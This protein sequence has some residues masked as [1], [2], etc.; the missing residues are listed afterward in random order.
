MGHMSG[1]WVSRRRAGFVLV[2]VVTVFAMAATAASAANPESAGPASAVAVFEGRPVDLT[3]GWQ[4]AQA[5][6]V[7][8]EMLDA[9]EC[10]SSEAQLEVRI[11]ELGGTLPRQQATAVTTRAMPRAGGSATAGSSCSSFVRLYDGTSYTGASLWLS[12]RF[13]WLNLSPFG[14]D[15]RTSSFKIGACS[16]YFADYADGGGAKYPTWATQAY[17][18]AAWMA[19][20]WDNDVSSVFIN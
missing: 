13:T 12:T 7:W 3:A 4:D 18:V 16:A 20:G 19:S 6:L 2:V 17:D 15:Q 14:F 1:R 11:V 9:V 5:C 10:F 8:P